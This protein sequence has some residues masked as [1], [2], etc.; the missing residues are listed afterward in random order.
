MGRGRK[1]ERVLEECMWVALVV[2]GFD[3][4]GGWTINIGNTTR[5]H[6][7]NRWKVN[8]NFHLGS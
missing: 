8:D 2:T 1:E 6:H 7:S 4:E 3:S 5:V